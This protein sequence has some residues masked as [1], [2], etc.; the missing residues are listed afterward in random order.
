MPCSDQTERLTL[1]LDGDDRLRSFTLDKLT[2][3]QP[4]G[5]PGLLPVVRDMP[6]RSLLQAD[7][8]DLIDPRLDDVQAFMMMKQLFA[9]QGAIAVMY[10]EPANGHSHAFELYEM[11]HDSGG[12]RL[13]G[14]IAINIIAKQ[15][16]SCGGCRCSL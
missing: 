13:V 8:Y 16:S 10:G 5:G 3:H 4:V 7:A 11:E 12:I 6:A 9:L 1:E 14:E 15:I 2:C